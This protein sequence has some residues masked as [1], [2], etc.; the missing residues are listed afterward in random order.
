MSDVCGK[1]IENVPLMRQTGALML[2]DGS[3][4]VSVANALRAFCA[5]FYCILLHF[6]AFCCL[7]SCKPNRPVKLSQLA[8]AHKNN[9]L[10]RHKVTRALADFETVGNRIRCISVFLGT[11]LHMQ[12]L[13]E[14]S[15]RKGPQASIPGRRPRKYLGP[16]NSLFRQPFISPPQKSSSQYSFLFLFLL[17]LHPVRHCCH[18]PLLS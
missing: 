1:G 7:P 18:P 17:S 4:K 12:P 8:N 6:A 14:T 11:S 16:A 3:G 5:A 15:F 10:L 9:P 2:G 13:T